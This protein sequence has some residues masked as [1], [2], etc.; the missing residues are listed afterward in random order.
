MG[1]KGWR[2]HI[3][4]LLLASI[5][6][7]LNSASIHTAA[8]LEIE[9]GRGHTGSSGRRKSLAGSRGRARVGV[10]IFAV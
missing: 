8:C 10:A 7:N 2:L 9:Q 1:V 4:A 5:P 3:V 6:L